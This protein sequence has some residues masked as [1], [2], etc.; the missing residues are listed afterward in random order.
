VITDRIDGVI[1]RLGTYWNPL[2]V[3][4]GRE[5][6]IIDGGVLPLYPLVAETVLSLAREIPISHWIV[7]HA[8]FDHCGLLP[9]LRDELPGCQICASASAGR[10][11]G[12]AKA[13]AFIEEQNRMLCRLN[14]MAVPE[15]PRSALGFQID[16]CLGEGDEIDLGSGVRLLF[17]SSRGHSECGISV[18]LPKQQ[19]LFPS[20]A[21]GACVDEEVFP[22]IFHS[23]HE[24]AASLDRLEALRPRRI[25]P[26]HYQHQSESEAHKLFDR[27]REGVEVFQRLLSG[28]ARG[29]DVAEAIEKVTVRYYPKLARG[30]LPREMFVKSLKAMWQIIEEGR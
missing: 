22:L 24:Y 9:Y 16:R 19:V 28:C 23:Y 1:L 27:A 15:P 13:A 18:W 6:A 10:I 5:A 2:Y 14:A 26:G 30:L 29:E 8:H 20:D 11:L 21:L 3:V 25:M 7:T 4:V 17:A 12:Q